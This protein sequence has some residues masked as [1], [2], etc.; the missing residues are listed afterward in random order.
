MS[1]KLK[2]G[3]IVTCKVTSMATFGAFVETDEDVLCLLHITDISWTKR[4]RHPNEALRLGQVITCK[5]IKIDIENCRIFVSL[6][7]MTADPWKTGSSHFPVGK[8]VAAPIVKLLD[9]GVVVKLAEGIEGFVPTSKLPV[10]NF[11]V[12]ADHYKV[13]QLLTGRITSKDA[14]LHKIVVSCLPLTDDYK[15]QCVPHLEYA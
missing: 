3:D 10:R 9:R 12:P 8:T 1:D 2:E 4:I 6:K 11:R 15:Q 7:A 5:V 13:G 14:D